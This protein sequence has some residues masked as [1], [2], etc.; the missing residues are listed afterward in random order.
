MTYTSLFKNP[1]I[2]LSKAYL[3]MNMEWTGRLQ[4]GKINQ[5]RCHEG[6]D[7]SQ[8]EY[9]KGGT[10]RSKEKR[11]RDPKG[12]TAVSLGWKPPTSSPLL[13]LSGAS[14]AG[15]GVRF[16]SATAFSISADGNSILPSV[17]VKTLGYPSLRPMHPASNPSGSPSGSPGFETY[18]IAA[19]SH[20]LH[21]CY[22]LDPS[23]HHPG[24]GII[25]I[26]S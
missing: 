2:V 15:W 10:W 16:S 8:R 20:H 18:P 25:S 6:S 12:G 19:F 5:G 21:Y 4:P 1:S 14:A 13:L 26:A 23:H 7:P 11:L 9:W 22:C 17:K 3:C 24:L